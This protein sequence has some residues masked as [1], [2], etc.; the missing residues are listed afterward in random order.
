MLP[1]ADMPAMPDWT[2]AAETADHVAPDTRGL[3]LLTGFGGRP[4]GVV[5]LDALTRVPADAR[6]RVRASHLGIPLSALPTVSPATSATAA[7]TS[8]LPIAV[9]ADDGTLLGV[10]GPDQLHAITRERPRVATGKG[11]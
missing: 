4:T 2:L 7:L 6:G 8:G 3:A 5:P 10:I 9:V 1:V 11:G